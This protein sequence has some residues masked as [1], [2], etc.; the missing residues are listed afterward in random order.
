MSKNSL[1]KWFI[2]KC[3]EKDVIKISESKEINIQTD[4]GSY[5]IIVERY[6]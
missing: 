6:K 3:L 1:A 5:N 4:Y 2:D